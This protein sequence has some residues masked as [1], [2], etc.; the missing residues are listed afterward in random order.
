MN[1]VC[2]KTEVQYGCV[3]GQAQKTF[4]SHATIPVCAEYAEHHDSSSKG[5]VSVAQSEMDKVFHCVLGTPRCS[6][7]ALMYKVSTDQPL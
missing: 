7:A 1:P 6:T 3:A 2:G 4:C 5:E